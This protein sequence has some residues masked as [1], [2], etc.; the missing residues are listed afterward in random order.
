VATVEA[1]RIGLSPVRIE[2]L[3]G[4]VTIRVEAMRDSLERIGR[5]DLRRARERLVDDFAPD[6]TRHILF[7]GNRVGFVAVRLR[8]GELNLEHLYLRPLYQGRGIGSA[9]LAIVFDEADQHGL[10]LRVG[11][12]RGS[13]SNQFYSKHGFIIVSE[14]QW[15]IYYLR[16]PNLSRMAGES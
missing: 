1:T 11:A 9:V 10:P 8:T 7:D 12:L 16:A 15:D 3:E 14:T 2:D 4:L 5:F 13:S 6:S